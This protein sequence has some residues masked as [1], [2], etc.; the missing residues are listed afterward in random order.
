MRTQYPLAV[1]LCL[2]VMFGMFAGSGFNDIVRGDVA[3]EQVSDEL[4]ERANDSAISNNESVSGSRAASDE[5]SLVGVIIGAG[6][7]LMQIVGMIALMPVTLQNLGFP[8]WFAAPVGSIVYVIAGIG[9]L[10]FVT[11]RLYE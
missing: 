2:A 8:T 5:G 9:I 3:G 11:G 1:M 6:Q 10:Q 4:D 7:S